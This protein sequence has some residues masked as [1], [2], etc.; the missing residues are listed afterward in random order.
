M[1]DRFGHTLESKPDDGSDDAVT[2]V[3]RIELIT[4]AGRRRQWS[5][6]ERPA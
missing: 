5:D 6:D 4:G 1:S 2:S 3:R